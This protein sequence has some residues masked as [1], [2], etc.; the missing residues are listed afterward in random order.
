[1]TFIFQGTVAV[2]WAGFSSGGV[3]KLQS[4]C[5]WVPSLLEELLVEWKWLL[6]LRKAADQFQTHLCSQL[7]WALGSQGLKETFVIDFFFFFLICFYLRI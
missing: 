5:P 2:V 4:A 1:M 7:R 6:H 3:E